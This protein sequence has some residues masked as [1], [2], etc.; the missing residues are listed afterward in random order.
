[1]SDESGNAPAEGKTA[2]DLTEADF[3]AV[4]EKLKAQLEEGRKVRPPNVLICTPAYGGLFYGEYFGAIHETLRHLSQLGYAA[5]LFT[6]KHESLIP[7]GRNTCAWQ[8]LCTGPGGAPYDKL[9]FLDADLGWDPK[10]IQ[11][12]LESDKRLVGGTYPKKTFPIS[13]VVNA[14]IEDWDLL[15]PKKLDPVSFDAWRKAK[16]NAKGE[17]QVRHIPTGMMMIDVSLL[18]DLMPHVRTYIGTEPNAGSSVLMWEYFPSGPDPQGGVEATYWS[19]DW[20]FC[21]LI[22]KHFPQDGVWLNSRCIATHTGSYTFNAG[23]P[24]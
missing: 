3:A 10:M 15:N 22:L 5:S 7:R 20:A 21:E 23:L 17:I 4:R 11:M 14:K 16:A 1:M 12:L 2:K 6:M 13:L 18:I 19:E 9:L 24:L 8:A